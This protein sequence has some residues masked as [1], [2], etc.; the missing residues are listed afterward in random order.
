MRR[1]H[2][3]SRYEQQAARFW[4]QEEGGYPTVQSVAP[5]QDLE[6]C[7]SNSRHTFDIDIFFEG[8]RRVWMQRVGPIAGR[9]QELPEDASTSGCGWKPS[10]GLNIPLD[11]PSGIYTALFLSGQGPR[12]M[13]FVV[14]AAEPRANCLVTIA[15]NTYAAYNNVG[16]KSMYD[17]LSTDRLRAALV[18]FNRPLTESL[19]NY[20]LWD[21]FFVQ[22]LEAEGYRFDY[23][24]NTD[25]DHDPNLLEAYRCNLRIGHDEYN[26]RDELESVDRF[27][28][29][30]GNLLVMSG[31]AF[32]WLVEPFSDLS[33]YRCEKRT[34]LDDPDQTWMWNEIAAL[35]QR[36]LGVSYTSMVHQKTPD[37]KVF[38][39]D[40]AGDFGYFRVERPDHWLFD[41]TDTARGDVFGRDDSVVG[42]ETDA[43]FLAFGA[44][45][46]PVVTGDDGVDPDFEVLAL[47]NAVATHEDKV[48]R[49]LQYRDTDGE[50]DAWGTIVINERSTGGTTLTIPTIEWG[51]GLGS[52]PVVSLITKN[53]LNRLT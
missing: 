23:C 26:S 3:W 5:G 37:P 4:Y 20:H 30:G 45:G 48:L 51:H 32:W 27:V 44:D 13:L 43:P 16:G 22:W 18:S 53:A 33:G 7:V 14:R 21:H 34:S 35:R 10:A 17:H 38:R 46:R 9:L 2:L 25:L 12:E 6:F 1:E 36:L 42:P 28:N 41:G 40:T 29:A 50:A 31:N 39:A 52:D 47:A 24:I 11:W 49:G 19:G 15:T 8:E